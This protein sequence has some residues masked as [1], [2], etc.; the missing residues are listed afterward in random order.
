[1]KTYFL[2]QV[3][4]FDGRKA[5]VNLSYVKIGQAKKVKRR[6]VSLQA[7]NPLPLI[8]LARTERYSE[9]ELHK[10]FEHKR[11]RKSNGSWS[12]EWFKWDTELMMFLTEL[13]EW[14]PE[15]Y[16]C[17]DRG[18]LIMSHDYIKRFVK[19]KDFEKIK[20]QYV[21]HFCDKCGAHKVDWN[22]RQEV[23]NDFVDLWSK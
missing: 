14:E 21:N 10:K 9:N 16:F 13:N 1:M 3:S 17:T 8:L 23:W 15:V 12:G 22:N 19:R 6:V 4:H 18:I 5:L 11:L 2:G 7:G 20:H